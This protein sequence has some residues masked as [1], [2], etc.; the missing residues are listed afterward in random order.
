[1]CR[2]PIEGASTPGSVSALNCG[3][4]A[5]RGIRRTSASKSMCALRSSDRK[6]SSVLLEC[7]IVKNIMDAGSCHSR[8]PNSHSR[9][10]GALSA[11][12]LS[13]DKM[14]SINHVGLMH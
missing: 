4:V 11:V 12:N 8:L 1:M 7:P 9:A 3:F 6:S 5:D 13:P 14:R 2:Y 10:V